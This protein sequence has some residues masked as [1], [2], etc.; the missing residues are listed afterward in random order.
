MRSRG[1][2]LLEVMVA[3]SILATA[4]VA[5]LSLQ[6]RNIQVVAE[7]RQIV[8]ATLLAQETMTRALLDQPFP[9]VGERSGSFDD[10]PPFVWSVEVRPAGL[11]ELAEL[12]REIHVRV[13]WDRGETDRVELITHVRKP[14]L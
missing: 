12:L 9:D 5:L 11:A 3:L 1:F 6:A 4:L 14:D 13:A 7:D 8:R 2:T 10:E